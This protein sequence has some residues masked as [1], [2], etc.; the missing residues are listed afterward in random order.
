MGIMRASAR[1]TAFVKRTDRGLKNIKN[2]FKSISQNKDYVKAGVL[3]GAARPDDGKLTNAMVAV[4]NEYGTSR[5][6]PRPFI[7]PSFENNRHAY[8]AILKTL[9][10]KKVYTGKMDYAAALSVIGL[11][12]ASDMKA[13]VTRGPEVP[14][15]NAPSTL[16]RKRSLNARRAPGIDQGEPRTLVDTGRMVASI[17]FAVVSG[18]IKKVAAFVKGHGGDQ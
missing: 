14:P 5:T 10:A 12:M 6:E 4:L 3:G 17:T 11:K 13:Y 9:V 18:G 1:S 2:V 8:M 15:P 16:A 7:K